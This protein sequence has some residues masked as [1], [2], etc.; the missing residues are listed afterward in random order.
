MLIFIL[1]GDPAVTNWELWEQNKLPMSEKRIMS[2]WV[3]GQAWNTFCTPKYDYFRHQ[4]FVTSGL[5][6][7]VT[8]YF[9][10]AQIVL[11]CA[12][13]YIYIYICVH[14]R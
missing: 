6:V 5:M 12:F 8:T 1:Q 11:F 2:T 3:F 4:A 7:T 13:T 9:F 14:T 10:N